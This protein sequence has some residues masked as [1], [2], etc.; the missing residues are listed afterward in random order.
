MDTVRRERR[1]TDT[2]SVADDE[3]T[4]YT[5]RE[6]AVYVSEYRPE[7]GWQPP[8]HD[9]VEY[10]CANIPVDFVAADGTFRLSSVPDRTLTR[11]P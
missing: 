11:V 2:F 8:R 6:Y 10:Q 3:G 7:G 9:G 4:R 5:I 1:H